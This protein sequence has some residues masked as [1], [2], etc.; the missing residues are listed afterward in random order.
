MLLSL[1]IYIALNKQWECLYVKEAKNGLVQSVS[2]AISIL[3]CF[4]RTPELGVSEISRLLGLN[5]STAF[6]LISTLEQHQFLEQNKESGK[7][8]LGIELFRLGTKVKADLLSI[9][10]PYLKN[11][12]DIYKETVHLVVHSDSD[13]LYLDKIESPHSMRICSK[14][15]ERLPLYCTGV[16]KAILAH[17]KEEEIKD[18]LKKTS[19]QK[20][21]DKTIC[22]SDLLYEELLKIREKGYAED[23]EEL[24]VGLK[25]I[26]AP[27]FNHQGKPVG[28]ISVA[29]P[30][31][32]MSAE[33]T[34]NI[35]KTL[36]EYT[37][38]ISRKLGYNKE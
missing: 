6:G 18:I 38:E 2:R 5:K 31:S 11:L 33:L 30:T 34:R 35:S 16:G 29:G 9:A 19:F 27:I 24:E 23:D 15:G 3:Q 32:R 21:T 14:V 17:L 8:R 36:M 26:A 1:R 22:D 28:A 20:R 37:K 7:Y 10:T 25:C 12:A 13:V 4:E